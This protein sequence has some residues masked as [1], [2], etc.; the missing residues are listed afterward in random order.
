MKPFLKL[1]LLFILVLIQLPIN[2]EE[3]ED[4]GSDEDVVPPA[5]LL[6]I[7]YVDLK[8]RK[9]T[10][11][12]V[13]LEAGNYESSEMGI[14]TDRIEIYP[15][16]PI[17]HG[18]RPKNRTLKLFRGTDKKRIL[19]CNIE[20]RY[21]AAQKNIW[22]PRFKVQQE[23]AVIPVG[24]TYM[25][26]STVPGSSEPLMLTGSSIPNAEGYYPRLKIGFG[27]QRFFLDSWETK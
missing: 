11:V 6:K 16:N 5:L 19:L 23:I 13:P 4:A 25:P 17:L 20:I 2:A 26:I 21:Y 27:N 12:D 7:G 18:R 22:L 15:G 14:I 8:Q 10:V 1:S 3:P 9:R 24:D